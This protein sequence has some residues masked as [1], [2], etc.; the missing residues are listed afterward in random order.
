MSGWR[1]PR[2]RSWF[3]GSVTAAPAFDIRGPIENGH[4]DSLIVERCGVIRLTGW[5]SLTSAELRKRLW[6]RINGHIRQAQ[7]VSRIV[8]RDVARLV[9]P[10]LLCTGFILDYHAP[11]GTHEQLDIVWKR[12]E[13]DERM[14]G[15]VA[16]NGVVFYRPHYDSLL[17]EPEPLRRH[18]IYSSGPPIMQVD[19]EVAAVTERLEGCILDFGCGGGALVKHL[20]A[21]QCDAYG[22]ELDRPEIREVLPDEVRPFVTLYDGRL[23]TPFED[24]SFGT[25]VAIE[26]IEHIERFREA[27]AEMARLTQRQLIISTPDFAAIPL[28]HQHSV[29]PWHLLEA[30]HVSLFTHQSLESVLSEFFSEIEIFRIGQNTINGTIYHTSLMAICNKGA[31]S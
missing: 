7:T 22:I 17:T 18:N 29:V 26:V 15:S 16:L 13:A 8:R 27:I 12:N 11:E 19:Q 25:V 23:P 1:L 14:L 28:L 9:S 4:L 2:I 31:R 21:R 5:S 10:D 20:R 6:I 30:T 24:Q 3:G